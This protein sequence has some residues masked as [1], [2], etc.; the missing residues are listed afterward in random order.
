MDK[1]GARLAWEFFQ[2]AVPAQ[3]LSRDCPF[4]PAEL[5]GF[6]A[7]GV[8]MDEKFNKLITVSW[9]FQPIGFRYLA[10]PTS[11][12]LLLP[13]YMRQGHVSISVPLYLTA[14]VV[15]GHS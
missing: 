4:S 15:L 7:R 1:S 14:L 12:P 2:P 5:T 10:Q 6:T 13:L 11:R 9:L 8:A 3:A